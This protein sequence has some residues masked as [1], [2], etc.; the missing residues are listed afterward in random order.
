MGFTHILF[1]QK[2]CE[3][4]ALTDDYYPKAYYK[5]G[6]WARLNPG[7]A[8]Q[9]PSFSWLYQSC[10][11]YVFGKTHYFSVREILLG[12]PGLFFSL[13]GEFGGSS[14]WGL[15]DC[16][17]IT[18]KW[19]N[20]VGNTSPFKKQLKENLLFNLFFQAGTMHA[21]LPSQ[22]FTAWTAGMAGPHSAG[23]ML[24]SVS[25]KAFQSHRRGGKEAATGHCCCICSFSPAGWQPEGMQKKSGDTTWGPTSL[26]S[27][28]GTLDRFGKKNRPTNLSLTYYLPDK[29]E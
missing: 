3:V 29:Q 11:F 26:H 20:H 24:P 14:R 16:D 17:D 19:Y 22:E 9:T 8:N 18:Q 13:A 4:I 28:V 2:S 27:V 10:S 7:L 1:I 12:L 23:H 5:V 25:W 21:C 6:G 15:P